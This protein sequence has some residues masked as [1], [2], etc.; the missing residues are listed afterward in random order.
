[1]T[2][3]KYLGAK[4]KIIGHFVH[5]TMQVDA[6]SAEWLIVVVIIIVHCVA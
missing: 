4:K 3:M 2:D 6:E 1:M 5:S